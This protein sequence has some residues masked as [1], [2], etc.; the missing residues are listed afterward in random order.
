MIQNLTTTFMEIASKIEC[1]TILL[2]M[3]FKPFDKVLRLLN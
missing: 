1:I 2:F 3:V